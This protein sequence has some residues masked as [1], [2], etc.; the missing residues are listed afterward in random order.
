MGFEREEMGHQEAWKALQSA[1]G[2]TASCDSLYKIYV[3]LYY[4]YHI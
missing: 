1:R 3:L 2:R 4:I